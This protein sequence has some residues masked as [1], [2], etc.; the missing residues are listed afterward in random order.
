MVADPYPDLSRYRNFLILQHP[1]ALGTA[2]HATPLISVLRAA[3]PDA[4]LIATA[5]G[6][7]LG[8]LRGNPGLNELI[9][10]PSPLSDLRGAVT[11]MR[12]ARF[13]RGEP[14]AVLQTLGNGRTRITLAAM[15]SGGHVRAGFVVHPELAAAPLAFDPTRSQIANNLEIVRAMGHEDAMRAAI[16]TDPMLAE[17]VVYPSQEDF[18]RMEAKLAVEGIS[19]AE[20]VA[21][22]ITQTSPTQKKSWR[23]ERFRL[24]ASMLAR[25]FGAQ[26]VFGGTAA[27]APSIELLREGLNMRSAN[28]AGKTSLLEM[29]ALFG[30]AD[31]ALTLDTGPMHLARAMRLP[32][33]IIAPAWSPPVEWLPLGNPRARI[34]KNL[35]LEVAPEDYIIDEVS[36]DE[37]ETALRDLLTLYPPRPGISSRRIAEMAPR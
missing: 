2:I 31:V 18:D 27:E 12:A 25:E 24:A 10:T 22:F 13:F 1:L 32:M 14:Y 9:R 23:A 30:L 37:V 36:V 28:L 11:A 33:V 16:A 20:P 35:D 17:P 15:L 21:V 19:L 3:L 4:R 7:S 8:L 34:L 26:I 6:F 29:A 5:S